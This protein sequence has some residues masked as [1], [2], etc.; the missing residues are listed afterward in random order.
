ML[1]KLLL[2]QIET[3]WYRPAIWNSWLIPFW[4]LYQILSLLHRVI[5]F[6][7]TPNSRQVNIPVIVVG[8][9]T[10]GGTGKTP[11]ITYLAKTIALAGYKVGVVSRGYGGKA[12]KYPLVVNSETAVAYCGDEPALLAARGIKVCV[13]PNRVSAVE[14]I[15]DSVDVILSDDGLQ[16]RKMW[17]DAEIVVVDGERKFG[18]QWQL[19]IGPLREPLANI[20]EAALCL[21]NGH[22]FAVT[23]SILRN[24]NSGD[25]ID[26]EFLKGRQVLAISGIGNPQRFYKSLEQLGAIVERREFPD[27]HGFKQLD[28]NNPE[29]KTIIITE[30]DFVKCRDLVDDNCFL[31]LVE[32]VPSE[33]TRVDIKVLLNN[34][35]LNKVA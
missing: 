18:N 1:L 33:N 10:V 14:E 2:R 22:D 8:N 25:E 19:P 11:L 29:N 30:K 9:V 23:P 5:S 16:H 7:K 28:F 21:E 26:F 35:G 31:L 34:L 24:A 12:P 15:A 6:S 20:S 13:D 17:R 3:N 4:L 27:H 32:A